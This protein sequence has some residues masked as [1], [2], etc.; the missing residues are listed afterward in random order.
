MLRIKELYI[1]TCKHCKKTFRTDNKRVYI[2]PSCK[3]D[4]KA[5]WS[6]LRNEAARKP[7]PRFHRTVPDT[8]PI[9]ELVGIIERYN[10]KHGTCYSYGQFELMRFLGR[11][12][13]EEINDLQREKGVA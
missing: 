12:T 5:E 6:S 1:K 7:E 2:C 13:K 10:K 8:V 3:R 9:R 11:I 4:K